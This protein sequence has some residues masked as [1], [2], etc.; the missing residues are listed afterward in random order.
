M[1]SPRFSRR[2]FLTLSSSI[3]A[4]IYVAPAFLRAQSPNS[5]LNIAMIGVG[6]KGGDNYNG[7]KSENIVAICD[8]DSKALG[9]AAGRSPAAKQ[10]RDYRKMFDELK[11][12]DYDAVVVS[13]PDHHHFPATLRALKAKKHV[14]CEKPLVHTIWEAREIVRLAKE[15]GVATQMGNQ[16]NASED[17]RVTTEWIKAGAVGTVKEVHCWSNRPIWPQ[18]VT[19][20]TQAEPIPETLDWDIWLGPAAERPY[21]SKCHPFNWRGFWDFGTGAFGDMGCHILNWP[22]TALDLGSPISAECIEEEG[23]S[24]DSPPT[25]S[26]IKLEFA[27]R[28]DR[29]AVTLYWHDGGNLPTAEQFGGEIPSRA[30]NKGEKRNTENGSLFI[31]DKGIMFDGYD[32]GE[33]PT[34]LPKA[35]MEGFKAPDKTLSRS[36][37][38]YVEWI[39]ACKGGPKAG[40]DFVAKSAGLTE[41]VLIGHLAA[42]VGPGKKIEWDGSVGKSKNLRETDAYV[43]KAYRKGWID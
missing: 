17:L 24:K 40:S 28:G 36:P 25:K 38:H 15:A 37:G 35:K 21:Y 10:F 7:V 8:V 29:P 9:A 2:R 6:G 31:G 30:N 23:A 11:S 4:G 33:E 26:R 12:S 16:G 41:M 34:L 19:W 13:T 18:G 5:K 27:A 20:P 14:Y 42:R 43:N 39:N 22:Y 1:Q 32:G 3:A